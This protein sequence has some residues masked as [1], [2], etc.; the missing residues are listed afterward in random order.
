MSERINGT[1]KWFNGDK[2]F[3]FIARDGGPDVFVHFSAIQGD[4]FRNLQE[5]QKVEFAVE[6][7]PK[8]PQ[9]SNVT[10]LN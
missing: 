2:G 10:V 1:V 8:G 4:G 6:Q 9:A 3:G 5:G 7:G